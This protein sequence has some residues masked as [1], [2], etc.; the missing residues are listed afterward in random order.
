[1]V[2]EIG[3]GDSARNSTETSVSALPIAH[4]KH[5]DLGKF[6]GSGGIGLKE[7]WANAASNFAQFALR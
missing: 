2:I 3:R 5:R 6:S 7:W 1:V 4:A